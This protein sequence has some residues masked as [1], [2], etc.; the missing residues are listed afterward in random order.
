MQSYIDLLSGN[1]TPMIY[2]LMTL[3]LK[4]MLNNLLNTVL[5]LK[6]SKKRTRNFIPLE[7]N[8]LVKAWL[9]TSLDPVQ[10]IDKTRSTYWKRIHD[11]Y[12]EHKTF[13]SERNISSLSHRWGIIYKNVN[14]FCGWYT[15][16]QN[17]RES[18]LTEQDKVS[19]LILL[20]DWKCI[21]FVFGSQHM[22]FVQI[23]RAKELYQ[24]KYPEGKPFFSCTAGISCSMSRSGLI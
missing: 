13:E 22:F 15:Q 11:Y 6:P 8:M 18:G 17:R 19:C 7:D 16:V 9:E 14:R 20:I 10:G 24:E 3:K 12:H 4:H 21:S 2:L 1:G 5:P 23:E